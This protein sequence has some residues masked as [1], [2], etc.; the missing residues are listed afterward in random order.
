ME[1][2]NHML[3]LVHRANMGAILLGAMVR[4]MAH[5]FG[6]GLLLA[7]DQQ[8]AH[9]FLIKEIV[10]IWDAHGAAATEI[11]HLYSAATR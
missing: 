2:Q 11:A 9:K 10:S 5:V 7:Q 4:L 1:H 6:K 3:I 8:I